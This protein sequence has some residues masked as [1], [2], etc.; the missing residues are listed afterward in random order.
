MM[1]PKKPLE[2]PLSHYQS[3][4]DLPNIVEKLLILTGL[5]EIVIFG[6][7]STNGIG[8]TART[9]ILLFFLSSVLFFIN[10]KGY[11]KEAGIALFII[12]SLSVTYLAYQGD[13][14]YSTPFIFFPI[15][16]IFSGI[17]FGKK[18]IYFITIFLIALTTLL[19][20]LDRSG[21]IIP[22]DGIIQWAPDYYAL[23]VVI[24]I[25]TAAILSIVMSTIEENIETISLSEQRI[26][27]SYELTLEGWAKALEL[28][29]REPKGHSQ[30]VATLVT[31]FAKD[32]GLDD[33]AIT[34]LRQGAL[35]HDIGKMGLP[36]SILLKPGPLSDDETEFCKQHTLFAKKILQDIIYRHPCSPP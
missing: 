9:M 10:R 30:R 17:V 19:F 24:L 5:T 29:G 2:T 4:I 22:F 18:Q 11:S 23:A 6:I 8:I 26:K 35:L 7:W 12:A 3:V 33:Q 34:S 15:I 1:R 25:A 32:L 21:I 13:G 36:D 31:E 14:I 27:E 16:L 20:A 28:S